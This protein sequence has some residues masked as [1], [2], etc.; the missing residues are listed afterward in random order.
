MA[1]Y[2]VDTMQAISVVTRH[3][4]CS[5]NCIIIVGILSRDTRNYLY[6]DFCELL[7]HFRAT[8]IIIDLSVLHRDARFYVVWEQSTCHLIGLTQ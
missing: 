3:E 7:A 5:I 1:R 4:F 8:M 2:E 6:K